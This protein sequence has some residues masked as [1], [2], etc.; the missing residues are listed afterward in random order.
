VTP[1]ISVVTIK[2][3]QGE[4]GSPFLH[5]ALYMV[6]PLFL[7]LCLLFETIYRA[8]ALHVGV[9]G[10]LGPYLTAKRDHVSVLENDGDLYYMVNVTLGGQPFE[11]LVDTGR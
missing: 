8:S 7:L 10:K 2:G 6:F 3:S 9:R 4:L 1:I 11:V 5:S